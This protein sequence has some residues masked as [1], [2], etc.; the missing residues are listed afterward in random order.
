MWDRRHVS[1]F[2]KVS[3]QDGSSVK[4]ARRFSCPP[5]LDALEARALMTASLQP[6]T[7]LSVPALQGSTVPLLANTSATNPQTFTVTSSNPDVT[8]SI[9]QGPVLE[10]GRLVYQLDE[11]ERATSTGR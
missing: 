1:R 11:S 2:L 10:P 4:P 3:P 8:A 7:N 9:A 6:I 5:A